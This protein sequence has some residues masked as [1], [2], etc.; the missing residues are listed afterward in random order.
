MYVSLCSGWCVAQPLEQDACVIRSGHRGSWLFF[1]AAGAVS[2]ATG[3]PPDTYSD[4]G[5]DGSGGGVDAAVGG[6]S[7]G[8]SE[9]APVE[10]GGGRAS[11]EAA[12]QDTGTGLGGWRPD[13]VAGDDAPASADAAADTSSMQE[14]S[15]DVMKPDS[16]DDDADTEGGE[17]SE[18]GTG[19]DSAVVCGR[20]TCSGCCDTSNV[21]HTQPSPDACPTSFHTGGPCEDCKA[22]GENYCVFDLIAYVCSSTP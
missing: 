14:A 17:T 5:D 13:A 22:E 1:V 8:A 15:D 10:G 4:V 9:A 3:V 18:G 20:H 21:C 2:C 6:Q 19:S 11:P 7:E 12:A 16:S